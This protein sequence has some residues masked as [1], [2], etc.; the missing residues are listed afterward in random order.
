[1]GVDLGE[2]KTTDTAVQDELDGIL[3]ENYRDDLF[4]EW[5]KESMIKSVSHLLV[6]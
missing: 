5:G 1:M 6:Y 2:I 4:M 3:Q